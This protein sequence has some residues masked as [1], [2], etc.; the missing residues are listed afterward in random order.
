MCMCIGSKA[1][2][3]FGMLRGGGEGREMKEIMMDGT[4]VQ[5]CMCMTSIALSLGGG[6][7]GEGPWGEG[8]WGEGPWGEGPWGRG[9]GGRDLGGRDLGMRLRPPTD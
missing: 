9:L 3:V 2:C 5:I 7:L 8:P 1:E 4:L 6:A